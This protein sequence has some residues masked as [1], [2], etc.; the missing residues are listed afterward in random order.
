MHH[1]GESSLKLNLNR[2]VRGSRAESDEVLSRGILWRAGSASLLMFLSNFLSTG[3]P[4][5]L[6]L[7]MIFQF[8]SLMTVDHTL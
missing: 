6:V 3:R 2:H 1:S 7:A 4:S 5:K 8:A